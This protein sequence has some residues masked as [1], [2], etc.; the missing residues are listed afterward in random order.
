VVGKDA[1]EHGI[2]LLQ[3]AQLVGASGMLLKQSITILANNY[4]AQTDDA[5]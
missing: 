5:S 2:N 3:T 4:L 1:M